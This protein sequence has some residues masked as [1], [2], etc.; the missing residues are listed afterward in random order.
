MILA[1]NRL[2]NLSLDLIFFV[3]GCL[4]FQT[5]IAI[6]LASSDENGNSTEIDA[7]STGSPFSDAEFKS[8]KAIAFE[9]YYLTTDTLRTCK[10]VKAIIMKMENEA[11]DGSEEVA[12]DSL[13]AEED[14]MFA[15]GYVMIQV[16]KLYDVIQLCN[17]TLEDSLTFDNNSLEVKADSLTNLMK[18]QN[19]NKTE[20]VSLFESIRNDTEFFDVTISDWS[21]RLIG[22]AMNVKTAARDAYDKILEDFESGEDAKHDAK[23]TLNKLKY[24]ANNVVSL[25]EEIKDHKKDLFKYIDPYLETTANGI[26]NYDPEEPR[27]EL[28]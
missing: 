12:S 5:Y 10:D 11:Q 8:V 23:D 19:P 3:T 26:K 7:N 17:E 4:L 6:S 21:N 27:V 15:Y 25:A 28:V 16:N 22:A 2:K 13:A 14:S 20:L 1:Q 24:F 9:V 18:T